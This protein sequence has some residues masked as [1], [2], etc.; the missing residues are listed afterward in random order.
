MSFLNLEL[1]LFSVM[2]NATTHTTDK[3]L[4]RIGGLYGKG[5]RREDWVGS[6]RVSDNEIA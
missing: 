4:R 1:A 5:K 3:V 2:G 6:I